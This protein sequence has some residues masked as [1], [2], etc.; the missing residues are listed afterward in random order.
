[1]YETKEKDG[2]ECEDGSLLLEADKASSYRALAA[3]C[4]YIAVDRADAQYAIKQLCRDMSAPTQQSWTRLVRLGRYLLGRPRAVIRF[5]WQR[6]A[7]V[8]DIFSDANCAG[9]KTARNST[10]GGVAMLGTVAQSSAESELIATVREATEGLGLISLAQ[11]LGLSLLVRLHVDA[12]A[13]LGIIERR[14]VGRVRH[15][16]VG[17]LWLQEQQLRQVVELKKIHGLK[18]P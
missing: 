14:G 2:V 11:D 9:C 8:I 16:D 3:R 5:S 6:M 12:S 18:N 15:L 13:A 17:T 4:N 10:T 7:N 1:M